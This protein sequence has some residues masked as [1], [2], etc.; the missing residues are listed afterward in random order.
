MYFRAF[1]VFAWISLLHYR[2]STNEAVY[3]KLCLVM[4]VRE[5]TGVVLVANYMFCVRDSLSCMTDYLVDK[6]MCGG[7]RVLVN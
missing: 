7:I 4:L 3:A 1:L 5:L 6:R 2:W